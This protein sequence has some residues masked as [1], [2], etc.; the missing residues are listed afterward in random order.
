MHSEYG[1]EDFWGPSFGL[2]LEL[3]FA[4]RDER[5]AA[6]LSAFWTCPGVEGPWT[7]PGDIGRPERH[8]LSSGSDIGRAPYGLLTIGVATPPIPF[9][10]HCIREE[11]ARQSKFDPNSSGVQIQF[12]VQTQEPSDWLTLDVPVRALATLWP[13]DDSWSVASQP[14]LVQLCRA[15]ADIAGHV[16]GHAPLLGGV[17]G[18]EASGCWR[19]PTLRRADEAEQGYPPLAVLTAQ[20]IEECGGFV[21]TP[22]LWRQLA[23][24]AEPVTLPSGLLYAPPQPAS[25]L[26][27][28]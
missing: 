2:S 26:T 16:H 18:E 23:P 1:R 14:W 9:V 5:M 17:M 19:V 20:A 3:G 25:R 27:G 8:R 21:V 4:G 13:V 7:E 22:R 12:G 6:A 11:R 28:A 10:L 24:C 15:L